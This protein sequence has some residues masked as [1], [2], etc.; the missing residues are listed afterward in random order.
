MGIYDRDYERQERPWRPEGEGVHLGVPQSTVGRIIVVTAVVY[1]LQLAAQDFFREYIALWPNWFQQPWRVFELLSYGFLHSPENFFHI[2]F[3]M[4][5]LWL[6]G[7]D[8]ERRYGSREFLLLYLG[9][10]LAGGLAYTLGGLLSGEA[11]LPFGHEE[12]RP[13]LGAS[14]GTVAV[15]ILFAILYPHRTILFMFFIPMPMW[16]L[17][18]FIVGSDV[19]N[20]IN[21]DNG[22][23]VAS[24]AHLGGA[25]F[26][27]LYYKLR[28]RLSDW[29]PQNF[30]MPS[31]KRRPNLRVHRDEDDEPDADP[32]GRKLDE[33]LDRVL[34][35]IKAHGQ[36]SLTRQEKRILEQASRRAQRRQR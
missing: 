24:T 28:W 14:G 32:A 5:G 30:S 10:I 17:G 12:V 21:V 11:L 23:M 29:T 35:K 7:S 33:Q 18:L 8:L 27:L 26:A 22:S 2:L 15:T 4:Y 25:A 3:N 20:A 6:F 34:A 16:V 13:V 31:L 36:D 19:M 9:A 1:L